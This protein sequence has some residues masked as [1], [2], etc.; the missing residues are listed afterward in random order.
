ML[1]PTAAGVDALRWSL[2]TTGKVRWVVLDPLALL[3]TALPEI[4]LFSLPRGKNSDQ[5]HD[6]GCMETKPRVLLQ[7]GSQVGWKFLS[8]FLGCFFFLVLF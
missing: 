2:Q 1:T 4:S 3:S 5:Y 7:L 8:V 6:T